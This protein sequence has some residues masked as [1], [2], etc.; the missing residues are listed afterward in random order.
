LYSPT[1]FTSPANVSSFSPTYTLPYEVDEFN[2]GV[3][4]N[5]LI[6]GHPFELEQVHGNIGYTHLPSIPLECSGL[7]Q[8]YIQHVVKNQARLPHLSS[9]EEDLNLLNY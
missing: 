8:H 6:V 4:P 7:V 9:I 3:G 1:E 2:D 5:S